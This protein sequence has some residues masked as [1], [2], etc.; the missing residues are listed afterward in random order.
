MTTKYVFVT[1]GVVS[2]L[3]KGIA[4]ASLAAILES[5]GLRVT[6]LKLDPYINVD[7]GTMSPFQH[8]EVFVTEDGA[9]TDLDLG[10]YERFISARMRKVNNFT[11]GQIYESVLRKERRGDYLGKTV[12]VIPHITNE[13]QDFIIRGAKAAYNG[14]ADVAIVEIGG[15]VGD[16][17]SQPFLEAARQMNLRLGRNN[18]AFVHLTLVP[19]IASAGELKTKPTQHSVQ[20]LREIGIHPHALLC[21]ADRIIPDDELAKISLF[22]NVPMDA[23]ISVWDSDSIYKIP[24]MLHKQGL[25]NL[26]CDALSLSPPPADLSMWDRLVQALENPEHEVRIGMVGKY[27]DLTESYKSLSEALVHAGIHTRTRI[28]I[29]YLDSEVIE[30]EGTD[31][32]NG[33][34]AILVPGGFGK[35]GTEGKIRAIQYARENGVP[36]L[37]ICLG[38][39]LA[40]VEFARNVGNLV[41]ANST[42]FDPSAVHPVVALIT[43]WADREGK[44]EHRDGASDLGGTMRKGAQRCPVKPG[45]RAAAIYGPEVNER[46]RHRF[47]VNTLYVP[48]L[49]EVGMVISARTPT[50]N[51]PEIMELPDHP[52]FMGVQFHPEFTST[53]RDGHPLFTSYIKAALERQK[54]SA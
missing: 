50:E 26:V 36:F 16:I 38:M 11:T 14:E 37:G 3:G 34:D 28:K 43:E 22:S 42:E 18:T 51:L 13:I 6:M 41:G 5:R 47:E 10:H 35:R 32:L 44:V 27:V 30:N 12:Q 29:E 24:A 48:R 9:E 53:P 31:C 8:G 54:K 46:H 33:L 20:K 15:T 23:V 39:Q 45:S 2:S 21:R 52:W 40:V 1:G 19:F 17:E 25:D 4:A 49:E 7:P